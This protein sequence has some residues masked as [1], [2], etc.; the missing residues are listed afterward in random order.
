M[1][2]IEGTYYKCRIIESDRQMIDNY[3]TL[4]CYVRLKRSR[5]DADVVIKYAIKKD[6]KVINIYAQKDG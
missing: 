2:G 3:D 6:L 5:I 1:H 4:I